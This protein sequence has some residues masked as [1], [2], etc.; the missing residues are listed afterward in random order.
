MNDTFLLRSGYDGVDVSV[1]MVRPDS[2][3]VAVLQLAHGMRGCKERFLPFMEYM[4]AHGV[5]CV[6]ND[7]RG[8]GKSVKRTEDRGYMYAGGHIALVEDMKMVT[9]WA[10]ERF[11]KLPLFLLGHS[12][13]S[14]AVRIYMKRYDS[15]ISGVIICGCP[16]DSPLLSAT[17]LLARILCVFKDGRLKTGIFQD[18][19]SWAYNRRFASEGRN[20]WT[21]SDPQ[22]RKEFAGNPSCTFVFT[23]NGMLS[24]L[25]MMK[26]TYSRSGWGVSNPDLPVYFISGADDPCMRSEA[27]F[28]ASA[29]HLADRGY[30]NVSSALYTGMRHEVLNE[31]GKEMVWEDV[32][33]HI[34]SLSLSGN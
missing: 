28:H 32:L 1:M 18:M 11:P 21:C 29:M 8:H 27:A 2:K 17:L 23:A 5:V 26:E 9:D 10:H 13:G 15:D 19:A 20:A 25:S 31:I 30:H 33:S 24:L 12:M 6:A 4:A 16:S 22:V 34:N 14:L 3:P 7:H